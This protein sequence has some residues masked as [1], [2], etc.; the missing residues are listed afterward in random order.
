MHDWRSSQLSYHPHGRR[1]SR[2]R[3]SDFQFQERS[4]P[5]P[6]QRTAI[7]WHRS[8]CSEPPQAVDCARVSLPHNSAGSLGTGVCERDPR[9]PYPKLYSE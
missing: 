9:S 7:D 4:N 2:I 3:T 5:I 6:A 1:V 8:L